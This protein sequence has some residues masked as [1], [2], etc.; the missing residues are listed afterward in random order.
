MSRSSVCAATEQPPPHTG[1]K[2]QSPHS[3]FLGLSRSNRS[4]AIC[5]H[6]SWRPSMWP[7]DSDFDPVKPGHAYSDPSGPIVCAWRRCISHGPMCTPS[8]VG[9]PRFRVSLRRNDIFSSTK[10]H[11][12][13]TLEPLVDP[14]PALVMHVPPNG[15]S[16]LPTTVRGM[17]PLG[18]DSAALII[19]LKLILTILSANSCSRRKSSRAG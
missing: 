4:A 8:G 2:E 14:A 19:G 7:V 3:S 9:K 10:W 15:L 13:Q 5:R 16:L 6:V 11:E 12:S 18:V 17:K 1:M